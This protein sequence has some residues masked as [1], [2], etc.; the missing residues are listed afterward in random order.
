MKALSNIMAIFQPYGGL[1][2]NILL[3]DD[4]PNICNGLSNLLA[5][6]GLNA[7]SILV[8]NSGLEAMDYLR[9][10]EVDLLITDIQ[11]GD[12]NGIDLMQ[13][14]MMIKPWIQMIVVSAH[15]TFQYAQHA[16]RLGA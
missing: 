10:E 4:E 11:I 1:M 12:M 5:S 15:E 9:M 16:I 14:A 8:A 13:Q 3:V 7:N 2:Y 6:S